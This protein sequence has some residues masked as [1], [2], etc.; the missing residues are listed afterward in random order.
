MPPSLCKSMFLDPIDIYSVLDV[1][2]KLKSK[3]SSGHDEISTKLLKESIHQISIPLTHIIN[4]SF[5]TG[6][7]PQQMKIAKVVPIFKTSDP[8]LL[9]NYRPISLLSTFSKLIERLMYNKV[10]NFLTEN[11][12]LYKHQYGFRPK[13]S[14]IHPI[15]HLL[16]HIAESNNKKKKE[17]TLTL[18]CDLSKAFD[19]INHK[20]LLHKLNVYGLRGTINKWFANYLVDR[21]QYVNIDGNVSLSRKLDCGVP[22][23]SILGP[24]LYL[25]YVNDIYKSCNGNI[26]SFAD[27]TTMYVSDHDVNK[28]YKKA[29]IETN[30]LF[31]WFCANKLSLNPGKTKYIVLRPQHRQC[32]LN[33]YTLLVNGSPL[34]RIGKNCKETSIK[35]LGIYIDESLSWKPHISHVNSKISRA[36]FSIKQLKNTFPSSSLRTLYFALIHPHI[37][38]GNLAWGNALPVLLK[39]LNYSKSVRCVLSTKDL[40]IVIRNHSLHHLKF[41]N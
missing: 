10:M 4:Q 2:K 35:F 6:I 22:Q 37:M 30:K 32:D 16:N 23:G 39:K 8:T 17:L 1:T 21:S 27:D 38:Y 40:I 26:L 36:L 25:L 41:S 9:T 12:I 34:N 28:L 29:Q 5:L 18:F 11:N 24:L 3:N 31:N 20:I 7:V 15:I 19:V 33:K 14:T 13:H